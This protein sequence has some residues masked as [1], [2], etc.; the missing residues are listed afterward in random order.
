[1]VRWSTPRTRAVSRTVTVA[2]SEARSS[3]RFVIGPMP[4]YPRDGWL[5]VRAAARFARLLH[6]ELHT[7][8]AWERRNPLELLGFRRFVLC[9]RGELNPHALSGTRTCTVRV[10]SEERRVG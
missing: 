5:G 1:M 2:R 6:T 8:R 10:R 4:T 3:S 7:V 9:A